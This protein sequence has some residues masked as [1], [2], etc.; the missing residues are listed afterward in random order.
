MDFALH[1]RM[2][3]YARREGMSPLTAALARELVRKAAPTTP[4]EFV[5]CWWLAIKFEET[6]YDFATDM[7]RA[8]R[9]VV[10]SPRTLRADERNVLVR[11]DFVMPYHTV[12]RAIHEQLCTS[13]CTARRRDLW[14]HRLVESDM[15]HLY[16]AADWVEMLEVA[17]QRMSP[18]LQLVR[19]FVTGR[20][21][22]A[23]EYKTRKKRA[24]D[25]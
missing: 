7:H 14:L 20:S 9:D 8:F 24:R 13:Y 25:A 5:V 11:I 22:A 2:C 17:P 23:L 1:R 6:K 16:T 18:A 19:S 3:A 10:P 12:V 4:C 15:S 21:L